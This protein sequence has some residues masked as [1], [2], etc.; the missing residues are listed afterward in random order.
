MEDR[1]NPGYQALRKGRFSQEGARYF[2]T[3][4]AINREKILTKPG[5]PEAVFD[6]LM[7]CASKFNLTASVIMSDH[8]HVVIQLEDDSLTRAI[9]AFKSRS[10]IAANR[11]LN[12]SGQVWQPTSFDHKIRKDEDLF[13]ILLYM[14]RNPDPSGLNFRCRK[15]DWLWFKSMVTKDAEYPSWL[16]EHPMG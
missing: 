9:Q 6:S 5:V 15:E 1:E 7:L 3:I 11:I 12:R 8:V 14:W 4:C 16:K 13:P 10:A 2:L